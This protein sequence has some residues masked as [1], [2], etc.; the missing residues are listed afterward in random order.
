MIDNE[1]NFEV[2]LSPENLARETIVELKEK[3]YSSKDGL[4]KLKKKMQELNEYLDKGCDADKIKEC[5]IALGIC[6]WILGDMDKAIELLSDSKTHKIASY[7]LGKCYKEL[8]DYVNALDCFEHSMRPNAEEFDIQ[9]DMA[10]TQRMAG[11]LRN[12][13]KLAEKLSKT[14]DDNAV[15]HYQWAHCLDDLGE[16]EEAYS[17]YNRALE[18]DPTHTNTLFRLA[19]SY[20]LK[21]EDEKAIE[22]YEKC[23]DQPPVFINAVMNLGIL[24]ED[25]GNYEKAASC[26]DAVLKSCPNHERAGL[27]IKGVKASQNMYYDEGKVK[28]QDKEIKVL[29]IPISDFELSVRSKNCLD[30]M[31]I[32]TLADLTNVSEADLLSYKNF[33]ETSLNEIKHI[34]N[35]KGLRL[36][37]ALEER[38]QIS[39]LVDIDVNDEDNLSEAVSGLTLSTRCKK[40]LEELNIKTIDD[41]TSI[42]EAELLE[43]GLMQVYID[44]IKEQL[45]E[46]CFKV[47]GESI[48]S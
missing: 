46:Q 32:K 29:N 9:M 45:G 5:K 6:H 28:K 20:D 35:Q 34:L 12:A 42:T 40:A 24:Y 31:N 33:G 41:L 3:V 19:F 11:D 27:Y 1:L 21:G 30:R 16:Y 17:H 14:H 2:I 18:L 8:G 7:F 10:E 22:Y 23:I 44:E 26:F 43:K 48:E 13:L 39:K 4:E 38:K 37:Q 15:L 25:H 36:G 47:H